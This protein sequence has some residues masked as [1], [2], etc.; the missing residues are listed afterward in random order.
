LAQLLPKPKV[1]CPSRILSELTPEFSSGLS[2]V[3][4]PTGGLEVASSELK[5]KVSIQVAVSEG[6][7]P[8]LKTFFGCCSRLELTPPA[9]SGVVSRLPPVALADFPAL[10]LA[11][12]GAQ[13]A[14]VKPSI[15]FSFP[16]CRFRR[17]CLRRRRLPL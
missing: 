3:R 1:S 16:P 8:A 10:A 14:P 4:H 6:A 13:A 17:C 7:S 5:P 2:L 9:V 15:P 12:L 11:I